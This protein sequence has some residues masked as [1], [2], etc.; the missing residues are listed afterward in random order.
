MVKT[1]K[2]T[3]IEDVEDDVDSVTESYF[4][5]PPAR[6]LDKTDNGNDGVLIM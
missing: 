4:S 3:V 5:K 1:G 6:V 2:K